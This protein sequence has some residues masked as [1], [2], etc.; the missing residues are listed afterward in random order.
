M[1]SIAKIGLI[2]SIAFGTIGL[3][4]VLD[5][6]LEDLG[7]NDLDHSED[8]YVFTDSLGRKVVV[9]KHPDRIIS[10][11]PVITETLYALDV[12]DRLVGVTDYCDY[13]SDAKTKPSIGGFYSPNIEIIVSLSP[14]LAIYTRDDPDIIYTLESYDIP[15]VI[16][17]A[18]NLREAIDRIDNVG[19]LVD[20]EDDSNGI[21]IKMRNKMDNIEAKT[22]QLS[23]SQRLRCYFEVW[24][25]PTVA[26]SK[27]F[28]GDM[29]EK[30]GGDNIFSDLNDKWA[31]VS[32]E[33]VISEN[34]EVI[35]VTAMGRRNYA[36]DI[37]ERAGY[38]VIDAVIK[39]RI[40]EC[41]DNKFTRAGPRIIDALEEMATYLHP[42][43]IN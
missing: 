8:E 20:A 35:F 22:D 26:G 18:D 31:D 29:M 39:D 27:N 28:L 9:K 40:Y 23:Q 1:K 37:S 5:P 17:L 33:N 42:T 12:D 7:V 30:A 34:P 38:D 15:I 41:D 25:T 13:P 2:S 3:L 24:S 16:L 36:E 11:A 19:K 43:L 21:T 14:D 4:F 6:L 32:N 10:M